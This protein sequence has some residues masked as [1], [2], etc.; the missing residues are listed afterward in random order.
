MDQRITLPQ[1]NGS[2]WQ[3]GIVI[4]HYKSQF[5]PSG[6]STKYLVD[7]KWGKISFEQ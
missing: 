3:E 1:E 4:G 6:L 7:R 5:F 2:F